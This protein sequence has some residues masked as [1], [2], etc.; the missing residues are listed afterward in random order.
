MKS[1]TR[2]AARILGIARPQVRAEETAKNVN[3]EDRALRESF[4]GK[5]NVRAWIEANCF[6]SNSGQMFTTWRKLIMLRPDQRQLLYEAGVLVKGFTGGPRWGTPENWQEWEAQAEAGGDEYRAAPPAESFNVKAY[7]HEPLPVVYNSVAMRVK[8]RSEEA[9]RALLDQ[10]QIIED[11]VIPACFDAAHPDHAREVE[12]L[13]AEKAGQRA[14]QDRINE[15]Y[16]ARRDRL[17][18][19]KELRALERGNNE[20]A[21]KIKA[22]SNA[23]FE[24]EFYDE[25]G[26][27]WG[28]M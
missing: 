19:R 1:I 2:I 10:F 21:A 20:L 22:M 14:T 28:T 15:E 4:G 25:L 16:A 18:A 13:Q 3:F 23:E 17:R 9:Y 6:R 27:Q 11:P 12:R 5:S 7:V 8:D 24:R 26:T